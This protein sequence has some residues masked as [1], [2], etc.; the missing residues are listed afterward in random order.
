MKFTT[1]NGKQFWGNN[2]GYKLQIYWGWPGK[3]IGEAPQFT[4]WEGLQRQSEISPILHMRILFI[5]CV[6]D[7]MNSCT[8]DCFYEHLR[9]DPSSTDREEVQRRHGAARWVAHLGCRG[10]QHPCSQGGSG[11]RLTLGPR[12]GILYTPSVTQWYGLQWVKSVFA[13]LKL[14]DKTIY[15]IYHRLLTIWEWY[16][17]RPLI[18]DCWWRRCICRS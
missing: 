15:L 6:L 17:V 16:E 14:H 8:S 12:N 10:A 2:V 13:H 3:V 4:M 1:K 9:A 11:G 5:T 7:C 18:R